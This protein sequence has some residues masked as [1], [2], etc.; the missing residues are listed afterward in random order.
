MGTDFAFYKYK[1]PDELTVEF[2]VRYVMRRSGNKAPSTDRFRYQLCLNQRGR[3]R[4]GGGLYIYR[5][6]AMQ[7][8]GDVERTRIQHLL[9]ANAGRHGLTIGEF[10]YDAKTGYWRLLQARHDKRQPNLIDILV[11]T[12]ELLTQKLTVKQLV[13]AFASP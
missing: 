11:D 6:Y 12:M 7:D 3:G 13:K 10:K 1:Y 2:A 9:S 5:T 8:V 4:D